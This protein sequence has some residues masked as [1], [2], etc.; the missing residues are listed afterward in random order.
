FLTG[1]FTCLF[2]YRS[3]WYHL[4]NLALAL[5]LVIFVGVTQY[6]SRLKHRLH[7]L[8]LWRQIKETHLARLRLDWSNIPSR[9]IITPEG[10][11]YAGDL[12]ITGTHSLLGLMD[13]TFSIP[14]Q[15]RLIDWLLAQNHRFLEKASWSERQQLVKELK[16]LTLLRDRMILETQLL[17]SAPLSGDRIYSLLEKTV[18]FSHL[19]TVVIVATGLCLVTFSLFLGWGLWEIPGYWIISFGCYVVLYFSTAGHLSPVF[20]RVLDLRRELE[21]LEAL[22][23]RLER[24]S[25]RNFPTLQNLSLPLTTSP[26]RPSASLRQLARLSHGLSVKAHPLVHLVLNAIVPWDMALTLRL[27]RV[28]SW[29]RPTLPIW[30]DRIATIDAASSLATFAYLNPTYHWPNRETLP[31]GTPLPSLRATNLGHPLIPAKRR[32]TNDIDLRDRGQIVLVTGSNMSGKSTFLRTIGINVCLA[33]AGAPVCAEAFDWTWM[34]LFCCIRVTDSLEE[35]LSYFYAEVKRLKIILDALHERTE[36]PVLFLIDEIYKGTNNRERLRGSESFI[37]ALRQGNGLGLI[38]TH[39]LELAHLESDGKGVINMHFQETVEE[40]K[41]LFDYR[42]R[43]GPCPTTNALR[44]MAQE[45][46]PIPKK[47]L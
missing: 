14:G 41:L 9:A 22:T 35:G 10:H 17:S 33:Q 36:P 24:Q 16:T 3:E 19:K 21:K 18:K 25:F 46:L 13:V 40:G 26:H 44:I 29:L 39:D 27:T 7:R 37:Q 28:C 20:G 31:N 42:L 43:P 5:F 11:T 30:L 15:T 4:G 23:R 2:L 12:D 34:R 45:G 8:R 32:I 47:L 1:F 38:T 6:H